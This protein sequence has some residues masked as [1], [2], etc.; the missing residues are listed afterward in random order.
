MPVIYGR[1]VGGACGLPLLACAAL[2]HAATPDPDQQR[3]LAPH[4]AGLVTDGA[5]AL[6]PPAP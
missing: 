2:C 4:E 1:R 3:W 5:G 6:L